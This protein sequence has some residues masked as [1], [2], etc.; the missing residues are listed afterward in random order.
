MAEKHQIGR[1]DPHGIETDD[2]RPCPAGRPGGL[3]RRGARPGKARP[4]LNTCT[5]SATHDLV[6][7]P[8]SL[9]NTSQLAKTVRVLPPSG[10]AT[11]DYN[12]ARLNIETDAN[13]IITRVSCG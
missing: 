13:G 12:P 7:T 1:R 11:M 5:S 10:M 9:V 8:I 4:D 6:G 2:C 3:C